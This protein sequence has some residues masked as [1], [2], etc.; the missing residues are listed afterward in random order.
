ME[1]AGKEIK[2]ASD[3]VCCFQVTAM[4]TVVMDPCVRWAWLSHTLSRLNFKIVGAVM[5]IAV[6]FQCYL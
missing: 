5:D 3:F 1:V 2:L 6:A 4:V